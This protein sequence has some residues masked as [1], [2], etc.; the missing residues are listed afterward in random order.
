MGSYDS[1]AGE[2]P[3]AALLVQCG[4]I[5]TFTLSAN[6]HVTLSTSAD[7]GPSYAMPFTA[8]QTKRSK[9]CAFDYRGPQAGK[10]CYNIR[11]N[12]RH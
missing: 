6:M 5:V 9:S 10:Q 4:H 7:K 11:Y 8:I 1:D 3:S 2:S 12:A